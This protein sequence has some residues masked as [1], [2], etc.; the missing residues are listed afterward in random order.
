MLIKRRHS[1][2]V[3]WNSNLTLPLLRNVKLDKSLSIS[4][5]FSNLRN[6]PHRFV[7]N[8]VMQVK[9]LAQHLR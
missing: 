2:Q 5:P 7:G 8:E 9:Y 6:G 3:A 4:A 1:H